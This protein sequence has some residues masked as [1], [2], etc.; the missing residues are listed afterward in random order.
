LIGLLFTTGC[1]LPASGSAR[2]ITLFVAGDVLLGRG[3]TAALASSSTTLHTWRSTISGA[4]LAFCNLECA[5]SSQRP[6]RN[7]QLLAVPGYVKYLQV[8]GFDVVS[9][10]NNHTLDG[11]EAGVLLAQRTLNRLNIAAIGSR[12]G[13]QAWPAWYKRVRQQRVAWLAA[14]AWG[15]FQRGR[16]QVRPLAGSGLVEQVRRLSAAGDAVFVSLHWGHEYSK[17]PSAG[18]RRTAH[19]LIDVGALAVIGHHPHVVQSVETYQYR[20]IFYSLGNF[21][22]DRTSRP[23]SGIAALISVDAKRRVSWRILAVQPSAS[24]GKRQSTLGVTGGEKIMARLTRRFL[25]GEMRPQMLVWS[26]SRIGAHRLRLMRRETTVWRTI[27]QGFHASIYEVQC[28]DVDGD[29]REDILVG[30][31]QRSKLDTMVRRRLYIYD[32]DA[33][34]GFRP[35]WRGSALSR[36][37]RHFTLLPRVGGVDVVALETNPLPEYRGFDWITVYRWNGFGLRVLWD[38][39]VRGV[40]RQLRTG[41]DARGAFIRFAQQT[42]DFDR[43]LTLRPA[44]DTAGIITFKAVAGAT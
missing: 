5:L 22:F 38:T 7:T 15:P 6:Q 40:V 24:K 36:P 44:R 13:G 42:V 10:A 39:P 34:R 8:A 12:V 43:I 18:Q 27:A 23:Q 19:A 29:G 37:F 35:K 1:V 20:P 30:L 14:S 17:Q 3:V 2:P 16:A 41:K 31:N 32:A 9:T 33:R 21:L 28:G 25:P 11:G 4:D 26:K